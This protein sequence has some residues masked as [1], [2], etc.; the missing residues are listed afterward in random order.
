MSPI[1]ADTAKSIAYWIL[2]A[3]AQYNLA[4]L[5]D[6]ASD[7]LGYR[8]HEASTLRMRLKFA[9][10]RSLCENTP[11]V[12]LELDRLLQLYDELIP[13]SD[14][15]NTDLKSPWF[16][17]RTLIIVTSALNARNDEQVYER[18]CKRLLY[19]PSANKNSVWEVKRQIYLQQLA[20]EMESF[21]NDAFNESETSQYLKL[22]KYVGQ[23]HQYAEPLEK[24]I[25]SGAPVSKLVF[26]KQS[27]KMCIDQ[28]LIVLV[29][30]YPMRNR[31]E[32][33][34]F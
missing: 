33:L 17:F 22:S 1:P 24:F 29:L 30:F 27:L 12:Q 15:S 31:L 28:K 13:C 7:F 9:E 5:E 16:F 20:K 14:P 25:K 21:A 3:C 34:H 6:I 2:E 18:F 19:F 4:D 26:L 8:P 10:L 32:V 11:H 23:W